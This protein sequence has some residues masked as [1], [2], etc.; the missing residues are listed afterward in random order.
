MSFTDPAGRFAGET[1]KAAGS[2]RRP[3]LALSLNGLD[4]AVS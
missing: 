1:K 2:L 4:Q 3:F